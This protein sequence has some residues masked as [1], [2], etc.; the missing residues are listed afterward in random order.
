MILVDQASNWR[1]ALDDAI[2][3]PQ[4]WLLLH[5]FSTTTLRAEQFMS[6]L[7]KSRMKSIGPPGHGCDYEFEP[8]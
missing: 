4:D 8:A 3:R 7:L 5:L 1:H 6:I 2:S